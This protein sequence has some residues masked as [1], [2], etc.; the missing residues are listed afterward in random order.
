M[1]YS[2]QRQPDDQGAAVYFKFED[3]DMVI[4]C[5]TFDKIG[6]NIY[7]IGLTIEAMRGISRWG[8]SELMNRAFTGFQALPEKASAP[9]CF[10]ILGVDEN[11]TVDDIKYAYRTLSRIYHPDVA[12]TGNAER[13]IQIKAAYEDALTQKEV[14]V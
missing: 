11:A 1:P 14:I 5:D 9:S 7:A 3:K 10:T 6:C 13:F 2:N 8:C 12:E 4:A